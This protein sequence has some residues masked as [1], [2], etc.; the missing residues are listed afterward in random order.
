MEVNTL[1]FIATV[2]FILLPTAILLIIYVETVIQ[3][4]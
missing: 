4:D 2:I 1:A 3:N